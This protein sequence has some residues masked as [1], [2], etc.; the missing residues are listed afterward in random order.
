MLDTTHVQ[1]SPARF[2]PLVLALLCWA[3]VAAMLVLSSFFLSQTLTS[4]AVPLLTL[5]FAVGMLARYG[6]L[7]EAGFRRPTRWRDLLALWPAILFTLITLIPVVILLPHITSPGLAA[8]AVLVAVLAGL[9]EE[10]M[11][12]GLILTILRPY[13][14]LSSAAI[15]ALLFALLHLNNLFHLSPTIALPQLIYAFL[16]GFAYAAFRLRTRVIWPLMIMHACNDVGINLS[17]YAT[18]A[19]TFA[20]GPASSAQIIS[21]VL[22]I[23]LT[24]AMAAYCFFMLR[25]QEK[26]VWIAGC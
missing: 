20:G 21:T 11:F 14:L 15:S 9:N 7:R 1:K 22:L 3:V 4:I 19:K 25:T 24:L 2:H 16:I 26:T 8:F 6:W 17:G 18:T 12:R 10:A 5:L 13:G 23:V